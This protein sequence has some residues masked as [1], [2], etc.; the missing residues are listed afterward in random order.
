MRCFLSIY[1]KAFDAV[2]HYILPQKL[3]HYGVRGIT[4]DWFHSYLFYLIGR[5][6]STQI[7]SRVCKKEKTSQGSLRALFSDLY[8]SSFILMTFIMLLII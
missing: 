1:K 5:T 7:G 3:N 4:N 8:C 2:N 6:Q